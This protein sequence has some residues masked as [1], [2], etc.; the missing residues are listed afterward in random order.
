MKLEELGKHLVLSQSISHPTK[1][2]KPSL[3]KFKVICQKLNSLL[4][5]N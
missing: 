2:I 1:S 4:E 5:Q 3:S